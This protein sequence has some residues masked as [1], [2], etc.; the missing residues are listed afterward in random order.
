MT[1][2]FIIDVSSIPIKGRDKFESILSSYKCIHDP[3]TLTICVVYAPSW[4][5]EQL[6]ISNEKSL[7][8]ILLFKNHMD[9]LEASKKLSLL[10]IVIEGMSI[11]S[12]S[13]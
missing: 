13:K 2:Y 5:R 9:L 11:T 3:I 12:C 4:L 8:I 1:I 6:P 10:F 7:E